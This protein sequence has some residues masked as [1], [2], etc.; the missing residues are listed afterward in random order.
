MIEGV[1]GFMT[2]C[3]NLSFKFNHS[4]N[5]LCLKYASIKKHMA[6]TTEA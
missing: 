5:Y 6:N 1:I 3:Y 4:L 2:Q